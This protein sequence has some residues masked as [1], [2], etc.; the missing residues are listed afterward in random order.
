MLFE[1]DSGGTPLFYIIRDILIGVLLPIYV[2]IFLARIGKK[3]AAKKREKEEIYKLKRAQR[4]DSDQQTYPYIY[5]IGKHGN[6]SL[7]VRYGIANQKKNV[8]EY[9]YYIKGGAK[10]RNPD[11]DIISYVDSNT[12]RLQKTN[13]VGDDRFEVQ[14][15]DHRNRRAIAIIEVGTEYVKT[16]YPLRDSWFNE[17]LDLEQTLKGNGSFTL[18][19]LATFHVNRIVSRNQ[20]N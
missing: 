2:G 3:V 10:K 8:K 6:E 11:R 15:T 18:K 13:K 19:E 5:K 20:Q 4:R 16:F 14:L 17:N 7:A 9:W 12:I 1:D